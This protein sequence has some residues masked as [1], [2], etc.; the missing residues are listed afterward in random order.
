MQ[1]SSGPVRNIE[2]SFDGIPKREKELERGA[3][4][5]TNLGNEYWKQ[6]FES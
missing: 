3:L 4:F 1:Y 6:L 5:G 2:N